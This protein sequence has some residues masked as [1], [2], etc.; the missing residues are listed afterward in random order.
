VI[1]N[2][3]FAMRVTEA[4]M[5]SDVPHILIVGQDSMIGSTLSACLRRIGIPVI[6]TSR[7]PERVAE[8]T[9]YLDLSERISEWD[10]PCPISAAVVCASITSL[11]T[12]KKN[13]ETTAKVNVHGV[14]DLVK[15][16]VDMGAFVVFLST[17][18]VFDGSSPFVPPDEKWSPATEY[19]RQKAHV[20]E[21]L[22][23]EGDAVC[24]FRLTKVIGPS[25]SLFQSWKDALVNRTT[26]HPFSDM[27]LSPIPLSCVVSSLRLILENRISGVLQLSGRRDMS[28]AEAAFMG[29]E[30]LGCPS[31]LVEPVSVLDHHIQTET[32]PRHT[33]LNVDRLREKLGI[34]VPKVDWT[35]RTAFI[36]PEALAEC[37]HSESPGGRHRNRRPF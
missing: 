17:N 8:Y 36:E 27:F 25:Y 28:Y 10:C 4:V 2:A 20:E 15:R 23:G 34:E 16:L 24:I 37:N 14:G 22:I 3:R 12:C 29:A 13:P 32:L 11:E 18:L 31:S 21:N 5:K 1:A 9:V 6:G 7:R 19:G 33:T 35:V 26:I 30:E